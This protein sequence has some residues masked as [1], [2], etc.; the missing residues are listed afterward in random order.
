MLPLEDKCQWK[1]NR[2]T[3]MKSNSLK[4]RLNASDKVRR[5]L[6]GI[7]HKTSVATALAVCPKSLLWEKTAWLQHSR[8]GQLIQKP[9]RIGDLL[10]QTAQQ[11]KTRLTGAY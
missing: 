7:V 4:L 10:Y 6:C 3:W 11:M 5:G 1:E 9:L 2:A 8:S